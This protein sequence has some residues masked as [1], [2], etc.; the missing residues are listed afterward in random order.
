MDI[1]TAIHSSIVLKC[2]FKWFSR[3]A[4]FKREAFIVPLYLSRADYFSRFLHSN[5]LYSLVTDTAWAINTELHQ[6]HRAIGL[7]EKDFFIIGPRQN[8]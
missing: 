5:G 6:M 3:V 7:S 1:V 4:I 2:F 8:V